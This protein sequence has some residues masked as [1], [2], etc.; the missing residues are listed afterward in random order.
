MSS[1]YKK[2]LSND[3]IAGLTSAHNGPPFPGHGLQTSQVVVVEDIELGNPVAG[4]GSPKLNYDE[5]P[6]PV[7]GQSH[8]FSVAHLEQKHQD[9]ENRKESRIREDFKVILTKGQR[10]RTWEVSRVGRI[11]T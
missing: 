7:R 2:R 4:D 11:S 6:S 8:R 5:E 1:E 3:R 9:F 10:G